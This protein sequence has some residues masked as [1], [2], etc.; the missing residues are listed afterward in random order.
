MH[1]AAPREAAVR[2]WEVPRGQTESWPAARWG[3]SLTAL[4][5]GT[6][7]IGGWSQSDDI[8]KV[9]SLRIRE[10][11]AAW[12]SCGANSEHSPPTT[13]FHTAV[14]LEDG[15]RLA[16]YGG[17]ANNSSAKGLWIWEGDCERWSLLSRDGPALAGHAAGIV[18]S[19]LVLFGGVER[20]GQVGDDC[21]RG[22]VAAFDFRAGRWDMDYA[23]HL[24]E[25]TA[26]PSPRRNPAYCTFGKYLI[27]SGG[28]DDQSSSPIS[29]TWALDV[30]GECWHKL[31]GSLEHPSAALEGHKAIVS[32]F[33][34]FTFGGHSTPGR[35]PSRAMS[36]HA[37]SLGDG[38]GNPSLQRPGKEASGVGG[39][40]EE[41]E[42]SENDEMEME[43]DDDESEDDDDAM[44]VLLVNG[45]RMLLPR[46]LIM[47]LLAQQM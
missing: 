34:I 38:G 41:D 35:Y 18:N 21:F 23:A 3:A 8:D 19:R 25:G 6:Y 16:L 43:E 17:L 12:S 28:F 46:R 15:H 26:R 44:G 40:T 2:I 7:L 4:R 30:P 22:S 32:G 47:R 29:E 45:Q 9:W 31:L 36:V 11:A 5:Q 10:G 39:N 24:P 14:A 13:A 37:L 42:G 27:V 20:G 33:D 1:E